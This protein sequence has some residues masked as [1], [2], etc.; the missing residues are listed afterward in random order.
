MNNNEHSK[1]FPD[2]FYRVT[3]KGLCVRDGKVLLIH[4]PEALSGRWEMPGGG[5]DFGEDP[6]LGLKRELEEE[7]GLKITKIS[8]SPVYVWTYKYRKLRNLDWYYSFVVAYQVEFENLDFK[9]TEECDRIDFFT[10]EQLQ[11]LELEGQAN[12]LPEIFN[13]EDFEKVFDK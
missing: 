9:L 8:D 2:S 4:E 5:L 12:R 10:K 11:T 7:M 13:P 1:D 6:K 3:V